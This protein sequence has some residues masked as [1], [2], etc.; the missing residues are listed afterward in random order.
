[1]NTGPVL[2]THHSSL[3][4][5]TAFIKKN[6]MPLQSLTDFKEEYRFACVNLWDD[7]LDCWF[8]A[9]GHM[10]LRGMPM[11]GEWKYEPG[12]GGCETWD[13]SHWYHLFAEASDTL[14]SHIAA[15]MF[16]YLGLL[17]HYGINA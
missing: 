16:R 15:Y 10:Y 8:E 1:M 2:I 11:P 17:E 9:A 4:L 13:D 6:K 5:L 14:L 3:P 7:A 12:L